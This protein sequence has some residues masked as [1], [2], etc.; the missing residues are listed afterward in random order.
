MGT[1]YPGLSDYDASLTLPPCLSPPT[2]GLPVSV[3]EDPSHRRSEEGG[4]L[5]DAL[6]LNQSALFRTTPALLV[7]IV[8]SQG[9][10]SF[11]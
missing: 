8:G 5:T 6:C 3:R 11:H 4:P 1:T 2:D 7:E 9:H 10:L